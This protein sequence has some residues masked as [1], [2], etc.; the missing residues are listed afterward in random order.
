MLRVTSE[1]FTEDMTIYFIDSIVN[2]EG[3]VTGKINDVGVGR[4]SLAAQVS[5]RNGDL[6]LSIDPVT[7]R[8]G[9]SLK[10][11]PAVAGII[12]WL[13]GKSSDGSQGISTVGNRFKATSI[14]TFNTGS[15]NLP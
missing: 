14:I 11:L 10:M 5:S 6:V 12:G 15:T 13:F 4:A 8:I 3:K 2:L 9:H 7:S 1:N